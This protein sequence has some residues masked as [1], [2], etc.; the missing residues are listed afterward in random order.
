[1][2]SYYDYLRQLGYAQS[3]QYPGLTQG[4]Y[5][6]QQQVYPQ[7]GFV[8]EPKPQDQFIQIP[9]PQQIQQQLPQIAQQLPQQLP[10]IEQSYIENILRLNRGK[11]ANVY[12]NFENSQWGSKIFKGV[13]EEAGK[14]HIILKD[15]NSEMRYLLL[16][17]Y[18]NYV[19]FDEEIEYK[20][21]FQ[22]Y[23]VAREDNKRN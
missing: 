12:M 5:V 11:V 22:G 2:N 8:Y 15:Y 23:E 4:T 3:Q 9:V 17:I 18:L 7:P 14:D 10:F 21:P 16:S 1:M 6:P 20:Y 13:I 19:T